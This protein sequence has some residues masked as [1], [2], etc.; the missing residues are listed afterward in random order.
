MRSVYSGY[1]VLV[2]AAVMAAIPSL[3][4]AQKTDSLST[5]GKWSGNTTVSAGY[6]Y[7]KSPW[8]EMIPD[9]KHQSA[10][11]KLNLKYIKKDFTATVQFNSA[12]DNHWKSAEGFYIKN[13]EDLSTSWSQIKHMGSIY[14]FRTTFQWKRPNTVYNSFVNI[15]YNYNH[16][17]RY[18]NTLNITALKLGLQGEDNN[19]YT[20]T[21]GGGFNLTRKL[22]NG[23]KLFCETYFGYTNID[24][25][26]EFSTLS[27]NEGAIDRIYRKTPFTIGF[28][29]ESR[30]YLSAPNTFN[31]N[32][33][34]TEAGG[35]FSI[36]YDNEKN[37]GAY[38]AD[39]GN[40]NSWV[41]SLKLRETFRYGVINL[42]PYL[43]ADYSYKYLKLKLDARVQFYA[44]KLT[45]KEE[46]QSYDFKDPVLLGNSEA[47]FRIAENHYF[48]VGYQTSIRRPTYLQLCW[49]LR[50]GAFPDQYIVGN[51]KLKVTRSYRNIFSYRI[52]FRRFSSELSS[53]FTRNLREV[54][55]TFFEEYIGEKKYKFFTWINTSYSKIWNTAFFLRYDTQRYYLRAD[56]S[57]YD[58]KG[59]A[60]TAGT[61]K[62]DH[63]WTAKASGGFN[64]KR[65][66]SIS[67][68]IS[69]RSKISRAFYSYDKY[70]TLNC[71]IDKKFNRH[72]IFL[73]GRDLLEQKIT[74][75]F[76]SEDEMNIWAETAYNNRRFFLIGYIFNF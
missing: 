57:Y 69:Y 71:R 40:K 45:N 17:R 60:K 27:S 61:V 6:N 34:N 31:I 62:N 75:R 1:R 14:N 64:F 20:F 50:E 25:Y 73:E 43:K 70:Y 72:T 19:S 74:T 46:H 38:L 51:P 28:K 15:N 47:E 59:K 68:D 18:N 76:V 53:S 56:V 10:N 13:T 26:I 9:L 30:V 49:Y 11:I 36:T 41:D 33:L 52:R 22:N 54:E 65:G 66:W 12:W 42:S 37:R 16:N 21:S 32:N 29:S 48:A 3:C 35:F 24:R 55:Q 44:D 67:S 8:K 23:R 63:Y 39:L 7:D 58:Y 5:R 2:L 4:P